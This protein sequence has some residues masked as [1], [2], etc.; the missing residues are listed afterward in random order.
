VTLSNHT[1]K[2]TAAPG[3]RECFPRA[4]RTAAAE[5]STR[6]RSHVRRD[7]RKMLAARATL[8]A[9]A[10]ST[11]AASRMTEEIKAS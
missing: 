1:P 10:A 4:F 2:R 3:V 11:V 5:T 7:A 9:A 8:L 6:S